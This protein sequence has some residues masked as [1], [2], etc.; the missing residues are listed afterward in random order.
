[1]TRNMKLSIVATMFYSAPY[2]EEFHRRA[3]AAARRLTADYEIIL[4]ND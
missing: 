1:M 3:S 4:V 2:V